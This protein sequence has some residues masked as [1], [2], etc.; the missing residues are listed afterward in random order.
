M[1]EMQSNTNNN[2]FM[3]KERIKQ[4]KTNI[5]IDAMLLYHFMYNFLIF[6]NNTINGVQTEQ[7]SY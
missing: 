1:I 4:H 2:N 7:R 3:R 6:H 5:G